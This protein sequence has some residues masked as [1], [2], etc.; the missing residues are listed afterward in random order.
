M[1][2]KKSA[3]SFWF[4]KCF[5][6]LTVVKSAPKKLFCQKICFLGKTFFWGCIFELGPMYTFLK[7]V[8]KEGFFDT[9]F[10]L[11]KE[12]KISYSY[13]SRVNVYFLWNK[14]AKIIMEA[15]TPYFRN[16]LG[17][18]FSTPFQN[19]RPHI[20]ASKSLVPKIQD[21]RYGLTSIYVLLPYII[22]VMQSGHFSQCP[23]F[24]SLTAK[25]RDKKYSVKSP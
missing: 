17:L 22:Y 19:F 7:S 23:A 9:P 16:G 6:Y 12:K 15:T 2:L 21:W 18:R 4:Q 5:F 24:L 10:D 3:F 14:K 11:F 25:E 20:R 13:H 8:W 1:G